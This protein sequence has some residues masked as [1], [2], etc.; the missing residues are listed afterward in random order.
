MTANLEQFKIKYGQLE[1]QCGN[2]NKE[3]QALESELIEASAKIGVL[4]GFELELR[5]LKLVNDK[6]MGV[7]DQLKMQ[8]IQC[9]EEGTSKIKN[10]IG[11][12]QVCENEK[13]QLKMDIF[14]LRQEIRTL[15]ISIHNDYRSNERSSGNEGILGA[16]LGRCRRDLDIIAQI[17]S[18]YDHQL[19]FILNRRY[20]Y[21]VNYQLQQQ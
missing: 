1:V 7:I 18:Q 5:N 4:Q 10:V 12:T 2:I 11:Q 17:Y 13:Q 8:R 3:K 6:N 21:S 9:E 19:S 15:N 14:N 20:E 16:L